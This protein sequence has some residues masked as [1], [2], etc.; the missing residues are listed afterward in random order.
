MNKYLV[1][2]K[3]EIWE[4]HGSFIRMPMIVG[5][6]L[7]ALLIFMIVAAGNNFSEHSYFGFSELSSVGGNA[8]SR[9]FEFNDK[10][11]GE[12]SDVTAAHFDDGEEVSHWLREIS[13][14]P[15]ILFSGIML[16][17]AFSFLLS[18]L[19]SDR[20]DGSVLFWKSMPVSETQNVLNKLVVVTFVLPAI[21]WIAAFLMSIVMMVIIYLAAVW[22]GIEGLPSHILHGS[23]ILQTGW[24][25]IG[26]FI[27]ASLWFLPI[28][29]WL[30]FSSA[31]AKKNV[32]LTAVLPILI[33]VIAEKY[34]V[35]SH[36]LAQFLAQH[37]GGIVDG[38]EQ[39]FILLNHSGWSQLASLLS[40]CQLWLAIVLASVLTYAAIWLRENRY[41]G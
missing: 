34:L 15:Y 35:H 30:L 5:A 21:A 37:L 19:I 4:H 38:Q 26:T 2:L 12:V 27:A 29:A 22:S 36:H 14:G 25:Y 40:S 11:I 24:N 20:K 3:R 33:A 1:P 23:A 41:E 6:V 8:E 31:L 32:F 18:C 13:R 28:A 7:T 16:L 39:A 17:A 9:Q 10:V